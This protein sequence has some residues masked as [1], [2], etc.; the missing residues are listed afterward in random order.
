MTSFCGTVGSVDVCDV[1]GSAE[2]VCCCGTVG[3]VGVYEVPV[4]AE[5]VIGSCD[6]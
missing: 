3:Y 5:E 2:E 4:I 1:P 6:S